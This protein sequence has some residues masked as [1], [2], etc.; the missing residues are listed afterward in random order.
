SDTRSQVYGGIAYETPSSNIAVAKTAGKVLTW[1]GHVATT[2]FFSTSGGRTAD[3]REVWPA[4]GSVPYLRAVDDPYDV[5]SPHHT[6]GPVTLDADKVAQRLHVPAGE[7]KVLTSSSGHVTAVRIGTRTIDGDRFRQE[8]GL[9]ST[10]FRIG[11]MSLSAARAQVTFGGKLALRARAEGVGRAALQRRVGAGTWKTLKWIDG[12]TGV[13]VEPQGQTLYRLAAGGVV[14]P[15]VGVAVAPRLHVV[16]AGADLL[17]GEVRPV[18]RGTVTVSRRVGRSWKV[19]GHPQ[20]DAGG[21]FRAPLRLHPGAY[22]VEVG[23]TGRFAGTAASLRV[24]PRLL[25]TLTH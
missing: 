9:A 6:W 1:H 15:V 4:L 20:I 22:R 8:L 2:F 5:R 13:T 11:R 16:P 18:S 21:S 23:A 12:S 3:V 24:T 10:V 14:G 7:M 17:A 25:A 19:V